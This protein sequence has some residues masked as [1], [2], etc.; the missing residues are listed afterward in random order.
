[1]TPQGPRGPYRDR[2]GSVP[3][4]LTADLVETLHFL[5]LFEVILLSSYFTVEETEAQR[6]SA[7]GLRHSYAWQA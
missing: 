6:V 3:S 4:A 1:M 2:A 5:L 7:T